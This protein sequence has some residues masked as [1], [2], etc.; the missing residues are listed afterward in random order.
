MEWFFLPLALVLSL[1]AGWAGYPAVFLVAAVS[2]SIAF[3]VVAASPDG[4]RQEESL[5]L[6]TGSPPPP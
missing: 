2:L 4:R 3:A 5:P 1:L 6:P